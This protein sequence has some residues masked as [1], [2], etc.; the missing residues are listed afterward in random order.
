MSD[1]TPAGLA[2]QMGT[3]A[4]T[5]E[6][7]YAASIKEPKQAASQLQLA[8]S[9]ISNCLVRTSACICPPACL[10][11]ALHLA[12]TLWSLYRV[13]T[14]LPQA[15]MQQLSSS[16]APSLAQGLLHEGLR[17]LGALQQQALMRLAEAHIR[18]EEY[19]AAQELVRTISAAAA[20]AAAGEQLSR[21]SH[22][23]AVRC[24][25]GLRHQEEAQRLILGMLGDPSVPCAVVTEALGL[26][27]GFCLQHPAS[28]GQFLQLAV[29]ALQAHPQEASIPMACI[30]QML[31]PDQAQDHLILDFLADESVQELILQVGP[32]GR[33]RPMLGSIGWPSAG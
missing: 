9:S 29:G 31:D 25:L 27:A 8:S 30:A 15:R 3:Q 28:F 4:C 6:L 16:G 7:E 20:A 10:Q 19:S 32:A 18:L 2:M 5:M 33:Q 22:S 26:F 13:G 12:W 11:L 24:S 1:R 17:D 21:W 14:L 23:A